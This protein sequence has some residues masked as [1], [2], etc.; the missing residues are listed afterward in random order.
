LEAEKGRAEYERIR[1]ESRRSQPDPG[2]GMVSRFG[3]PRDQYWTLRRD[4][5]SGEARY[6][7]ER[8]NQ[9]VEHVYDVFDVLRED[10]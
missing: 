9:F 2:M 5:H 6:V 3:E 7:P 1:D 4:R 8:G 10:D